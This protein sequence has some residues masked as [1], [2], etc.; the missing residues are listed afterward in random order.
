MTYKHWYF[1]DFQFFILLF[2]LMLVELTAAFLL[3][4][5]ES[6]VRYSRR[7]LG[8]GHWDVGRRFERGDRN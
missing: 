2:I 8:C 6:K 1:L 7:A 4:L 3:L 5:Y